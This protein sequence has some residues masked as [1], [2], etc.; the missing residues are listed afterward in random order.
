MF[1]DTPTI[2]I[3]V[4]GLNVPAHSHFM[5][6]MKYLFTNADLSYESHQQWS[7]IYKTY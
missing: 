5:V 3:S 6:H 2:P 7:S 4:D 1:F